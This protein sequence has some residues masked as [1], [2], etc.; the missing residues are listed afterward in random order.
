MIPIKFGTDG[1][2]AKIGRGFSFKNVRLFAQG[3][4]NYL[5]NYKKTPVPQVIVNFDTGYLSK[6]FAY[7]TAKIFSLNKIKT[8]IPNRDV[9]LAAISLAI[10]N[11]RLDGGINFALSSRNPT[12]NVVRIFSHLGSP[13]LPSQT[14]LI[15]DEVRKIRHTFDFHHQYPYHE[16]IAETDV[17]SAYI[18]YIKSVVNLDLVKKSGIKIVVD[19]LFGTS[20]EYLDYM[21]SEQGIDTVSIHNFPY[22]PTA[23]ISTCL[24]SAGL[25]DLAREVVER[26]ADIGLAT[27]ISGDRFGII[28]S[29]GKYLCSNVI[30]PPLIEYLITVRKFEGGIVK[31]ISTTD[32][33]KKLADYYL[34]KVYVTPVGFKYLA[35][36]MF[37]RKAFI[38]IE[39][40]NGASLNRTVP[41][42][43]GI[44]FN[45]LVTEML[46][47]Y[48][49]K[50]DKI[51]NNFYLK[52]PRL[53]SQETALKKSSQRQRRLK[54]LMTRKEFDFPGLR[55]KKVVRI[56]GLKFLFDKSWLLIRE[57]GTE[58][59]I[60]IY[61]ESSALKSTKSLIKLGRSLID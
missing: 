46:A 34:R 23:G 41:M 40:T 5:H 31:S 28:D 61:A 37:Q 47:H 26:K 2:R 50:L 44:L 7:E 45:L 51:L 27:D 43:D 39:S 8:L 60:R 11:N 55:L 48:H 57:S 32:N 49:L 20:R 24:E 13:S 18:D 16:L 42:K 17:K 6:R 36:M 29:R 30:M 25:K 21:L 53:F 56:D 4:A 59:I 35:Q 14:S 52:F 22:S 19:N 58:D 9:P 15:E 10:Q 33:I 54:T 1:W 12:L 38:A 3:Y